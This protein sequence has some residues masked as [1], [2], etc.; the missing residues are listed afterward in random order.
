MKRKTGALHYQKSVFVWIALATVAVLLIPLVAMQ[1]TTD[2]SWEAADFV[3]MGFLLFGTASLF[4]LAGRKLARKQRLI[5]G[6]ILVAVFLYAWAELAVG[7]LT[8]L[9]S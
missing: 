6:G 7:L 2:V 1:F 5:L 8:D 9:G 4:V 3:V